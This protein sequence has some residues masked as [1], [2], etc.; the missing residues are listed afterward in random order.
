[1][2]RIVVNKY[3]GRARGEGFCVWKREREDWLPSSGTSCVENDPLR[4]FVILPHIWPVQ[5]CAE[6]W[7][8]RDAKCLH[9]FTS[10]L[11]VAA[12]VLS[13]IVYSFWSKWRCSH[14]HTLWKIT[15]LK[16]PFP[17]GRPHQNNSDS[18]TESL[19]RQTLCI[20]SREL[21]YA[22]KS[23]SCSSLCND[24]A[25][26]SFIFFFPAH[27]SAFNFHIPLRFL[28]DCIRW[29]I[30]APHSRKHT[31]DQQQLFSM[32]VFKATYGFLLWKA[33]IN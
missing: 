28:R 22:N 27:S 25:L 1:M 29:D 33:V 2:K 11:Q 17:K 7:R 32:N 13:Q 16:L 9:L 10:L 12:H 14:V 24:S 19:R 31:Q 15:F 3:N 23:S 20:S 18:R 6:G 21:V 5:L 30:I 8:E 4:C 26:C